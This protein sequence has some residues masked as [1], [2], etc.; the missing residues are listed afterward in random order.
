MTLR[1]SSEGLVVSFFVKL[2]SRSGKLRDGVKERRSIPLEF[3]GFFVILIMHVVRH[4]LFIEV[5]PFG[6][7]TQQLHTCMVFLRGPKL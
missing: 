3:V 6:D 5:E 7:R 2:R 4:C 1:S